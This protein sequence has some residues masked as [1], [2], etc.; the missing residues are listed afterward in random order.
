MSTKPTIEFQGL[1]PLQGLDEPDEADFY[2]DEDGDE[3]IGQLRDKLEIGD[4]LS[5]VSIAASLAAIAAKGDSRGRWLA[6]FGSPLGRWLAARGCDL[7]TSLN[8]VL[9]LAPRPMN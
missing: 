6:A 9:G 4:E 1:T 7:N 2:L 3:L 5:D 8:V